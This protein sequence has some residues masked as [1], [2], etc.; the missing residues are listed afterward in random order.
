MTLHKSL[1]EI[2]L[3]IISSVQEEVIGQLSL[4]QRLLWMITRESVCAYALGHI[5]F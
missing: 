2:F 1:P 3:R 4:L 5:F